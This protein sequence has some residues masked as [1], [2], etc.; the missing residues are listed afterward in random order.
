MVN[1]TGAPWPQLQSPFASC[2]EGSLQETWFP[3]VKVSPLLA[4]F[5]PSSH[6]VFKMDERLPDGVSPAFLTL[7]P[8]VS[9]VFLKRSLVF[10]ILLFSSISLHWSNSNLSLLFFGT[11]H[12]DG[13]IFPLLLCLSLLFSATYKPSSDNHFAFL[14]FFF[15]EIVFI[16]TSCTMSWTSDHSSSGTLS[17]LIPWIYLSLLLYNQRDLIQII[18]EWSSGLLYFLP[19]KSECCIKEFMIWATVGCI[20][21]L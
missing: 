9:L 7:A 15:L 12:S 21:V 3:L 4:G 1:L 11:L 20:I 14:H 13:Y 5:R 17:N 2:R 16:T 8:T 19:F 18:P 6:P 10:P